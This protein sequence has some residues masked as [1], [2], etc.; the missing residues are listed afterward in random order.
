MGVHNFNEKLREARKEKRLS[1]EKL[2]EKIGV[3]AKT[4]YKWEQGEF[5]PELGKIPHL[6]EALEVRES[7]FFEDEEVLDTPINLESISRKL[8]ES[9]ARLSKIEA[10]LEK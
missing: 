9:L 5:F 2:A 3:S 10:I 7:W 1:Q 4:V 8:D 6:A